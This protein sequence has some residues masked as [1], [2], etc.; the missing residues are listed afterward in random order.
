MRAIILYLGVCV[1][2]GVVPLLP[3]QS[4]V[5]GKGECLPRWPTHFQGKPLHQLPL[6]ARE[7]VYE[8]GFP[9]RMARFTDGSRE[10][11][12]RWINE[13]T[14]KLH[15]AADCFKG[16]GY[17]VKPKPIWM[18][19]DHHRWGSFEAI[20]EG[21]TIRV[22]ERIYDEGGNAWSDI[23]SWYWAVFLGQTHGPWWAITVAEK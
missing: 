23:S 9:G 20:R 11:V 8:D 5:I 22:Y 19:Q 4:R 1:L 7:K 3:C 2:A 10:I 21:E 13:P 16:M 12:I 6:S 15:P 17:A 14:R 18:D